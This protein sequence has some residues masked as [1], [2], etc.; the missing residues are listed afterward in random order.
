[1]YNI[2]IGFGVIMKLVKLIKMCLNETYSKV[3]TCN[4]CLLVSYPKWSKTRRCS[5]TAAF[6]VCFRICY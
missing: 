1:L 4:I 2:F 6:K 5:I 3:R